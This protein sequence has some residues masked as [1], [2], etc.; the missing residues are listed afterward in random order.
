MSRL[1]IC[2]VS[3]MHHTLTV[4]PQ[5]ERLKLEGPISEALWHYTKCRVSKA[6]EKQHINQ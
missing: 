2:L 5:Q 6:K 1:L 3:Y 4:S